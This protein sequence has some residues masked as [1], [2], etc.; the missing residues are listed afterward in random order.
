MPEHLKIKNINQKIY[1]M[2]KHLI[3]L[4][5]LSVYAF[6]AFSQGKYFTRTGRIHFFSETPVE[7]IDAVNNQTS[8]IF[9]TDNGDLV[10]SVQMVGFEFEKALMQEHFNENY[11]ESE[12]YPKST[13]KG[14]VMDF[15]ASL[16]NS[17]AE[18]EVIVEGELTIHG[19]T[20]SV[21]T[22]GLLQKK[23]NN[24]KVHAEFDVKIK[25]YDI[26]IPN[27]VAK[28]IA[29]S[30]LVTIDLDLEPYNK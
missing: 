26:K 14:R 9:D 20:S 22:K 25:D 29:E 23:G 7:N 28:N 24:I 12:K 17:D 21:R 16:L 13:F 15:E 8:S 5:M 30:V 2:K 3:L 27:A 18:K 11:V 1:T 10:L 19:V 6:S 4:F